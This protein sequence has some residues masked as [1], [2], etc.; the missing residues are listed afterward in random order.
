M[1]TDNAWPDPSTSDY[2]VFKLKLQPVCNVSFTLPRYLT[3]MKRYLDGYSISPSRL[4]GL[5][6]HNPLSS[7]ARYRFLGSAHT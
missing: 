5:A 6:V 3:Q 1:R 4:A 2:P 7:L